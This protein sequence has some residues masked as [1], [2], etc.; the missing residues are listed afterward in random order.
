MHILITNFDGALDCEITSTEQDALQLAVV[1][2]QARYPSYDIE[3]TTPDELQEMIEEE[4]LSY[5]FSIVEIVTPAAAVENLRTNQKQL[6]Q[7]GAQVGVSRQAL[8][9]VLEFLS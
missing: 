1:D 8:E 6:D 2:L 4:D 9:E 3:A 7:D 5:D